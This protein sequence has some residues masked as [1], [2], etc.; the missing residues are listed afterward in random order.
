[1][2]L[3][4]FKICLDFW[5]GIIET[6]MWGDMLIKSSEFPTME[7]NKYYFR[8]DNGYSL[9]RSKIPSDIVICDWH[10][11][12]NQKEFPTSFTFVQNGHKVF[13]AVWKIHNTKVNFTKYINNMN[14]GEG[15]IA[16]TWYSLSNKKNEV[17]EIVIDSGKVFW[18]AK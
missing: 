9:L 8:G 18:N 13:G 1:M 15:M 14:K 10:Y 4:I 17:K 7:D 5:G 12:G 6:W 16:T 2:E 11:R 3:K